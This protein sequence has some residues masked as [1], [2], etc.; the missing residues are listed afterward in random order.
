MAISQMKKLTVIVPKGSD[1]KLMRKL[2][3]LSCIELT[4]T[5]NISPDRENKSPPKKLTDRIEKL[6]KNLLCAKRTV[7]FLT[8]YTESKKIYLEPPEILM[9]DF[10]SGLDIIT[11]EKAEKLLFLEEKISKLQREISALQSEISA[12]VPWERL[13]LTLPEHHTHRTLTVCGSFPANSDLAAISDKLTDTAYVIDTVSVN[14]TARYVSVTCHKADIDAV[15]KVIYGNCFTKCTA[16]ATEQEG[17]AEG[18]LYILREKLAERKKK[19]ASLKKEATQAGESI[20]DFKALCDVYETRIERLRARLL[21]EETDRTVIIC[22][23]VPKFA[24]SAVE[25]ILNNQSCAYSFDD[26]GEDDEVPVLLINRGLVSNFEPILSMY[27]LPAYGTF[28][29][30]LIMSF[31]Y[32]LIFGLMF[33]DVGYGLVVLLGCILMLRIMHPGK[34]MQKMLKMFICCSVSCIV[35]GALFGG[36]FGD[37]PQAILQNFVGVKNVGTTALWFDMLENPIIFFVISLAVGVL[38]IVSALLIKFY[39]LCRDGQVFAAFADVGSWL[40]VFAGIGLYFVDSRIGIITAGIGS[41]ALIL[42]QGRHEKN[43]IMKFAK[44]IMSLYDIVSYGS[45]IVS[46]SRILALGLSSAVIAKVVN[47]LATMMGLTIP[48]ILLFIFVFLLGHAINMAVNLLS[49]YIHTG[50]LQYLEFFSKFYVTGGK[51]FSPLKY[52]SNYV[53]LK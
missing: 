6:E 36:Y 34:G 28:D 2:Q 38:H 26:P 52:K 18:K 45:D 15:R 25:E 12:L 37:L 22:G 41:A 13:K 29:P 21:A 8:E 24:I 10:D 39:I 33:A 43:I 7:A 50:R 44:G 20:V 9:D 11:F 48:G 51:E 16:T 47:I 17:F 19:L 31:F 23:W 53:N 1:G 46:Y 49:T 27:S 32:T 42:T 40:A 14:K 5:P 35:F 3:K 4:R 30:T